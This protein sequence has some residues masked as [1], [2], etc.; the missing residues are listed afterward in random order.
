MWRQR[1]HGQLEKCAEALALRRAFPDE[2]D[3]LYTDEEM[4]ATVELLALGDNTT[5]SRLKPG[6]VSMPTSK[7]KKSG[8]IN[9]PKSSRTKTIT[10]KQ[11]KLI[12]GKAHENNVDMKNVK[13]WL[14]RHGIDDYNDIPSGKFFNSLIKTI[15][16]QPEFFSK[17]KSEPSVGN[18]FI[19]QVN[20]YRSDI[21][22]DDDGWENFCDQN[23][24]PADPA[25]IT[26]P[27]VQQ[28]MIERLQEWAAFAEEM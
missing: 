25:E 5:G 1:P 27:D 4:Q 10:E 16:V 6:H 8:P 7:S 20:T 12:F 21:G 24:W 15:E 17:N 18:N 3:K 28:A 19:D 9:P 23:G 22:V 26:D 2:I 13:A 14:G 11:V